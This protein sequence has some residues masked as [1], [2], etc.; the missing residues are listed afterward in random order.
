MAPKML[1]E[2]ARQWMEAAP[3]ACTEPGVR[4]RQGWTALPPESS[5]SVCPAQGTAIPE[6]LKVLQ[7]GN[8]AVM[9]TGKDVHNPPP[10]PPL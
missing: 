2:G 4:V 1:S 7:F 3:A 9:G 5:I 6:R 8:P 10:A